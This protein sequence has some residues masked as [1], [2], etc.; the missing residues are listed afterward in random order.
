MFDINIVP[1]KDDSKHQPV[2]VRLYHKA[3]WEINARIRS[4]LHPLIH[5]KQLSFNTIEEVRELIDFI[6]LEMSSIIMEE[7]NS[8]PKNNPIHSIYILPLYIRKN[9]EEEV[10]KSGI[11]H[12]Q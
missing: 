9:V 11:Q 10:D 6:T 3:D 4:E 1:F 2:N 8:S 12:N 5:T 7:I